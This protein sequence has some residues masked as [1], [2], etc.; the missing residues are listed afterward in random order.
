MIPEAVAQSGRLGALL[1]A[2]IG[3]KE[4]SKLLSILPGVMSNLAKTTFFAMG[5]T[6][7]WK[8]LVGGPGAG[9]LWLASLAAGV[10][11]TAYMA[12]RDLRD[13]RRDVNL[14][15]S[16]ET[17]LILR[18]LEAKASDV[19]A[20][21]RGTVWLVVHAGQ[22]VPDIL[23]DDE[24]RAFKKDAAGAGAHLDEVTLDSGMVTVRR[25]VGSRMDSGDRQIPAVEVHYLSRETIK[26]ASQVAW[27]T[28][29][30]RSTPELVSARNAARRDSGPPAPAYP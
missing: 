16:P 13:G 20:A 4:D 22:S 28:D 12:L 17:R 6:A 3:R 30:R 5:M 8:A 24:Y 26:E 23:T 11:V 18:E 14:F 27:F 29:G 10:G 19:F 15:D 21:R 9:N 25:Y 1:S 2:R 7:G